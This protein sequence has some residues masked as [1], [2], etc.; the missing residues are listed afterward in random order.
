[1]RSISIFSY[2]DITNI[3]GPSERYVSSRWANCLCKF[4]NN[5][6]SSS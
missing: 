6:N 4:I 3:V 2:C 5:I 1:M